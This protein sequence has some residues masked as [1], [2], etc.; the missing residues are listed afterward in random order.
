MRNQ[1]LHLEWQA[2]GTEREQCPGEMNGSLCRQF[3]ESR[4]GEGRQESLALT[5]HPKDATSAAV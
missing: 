2:A 5:R 1:V 4:G 3:A